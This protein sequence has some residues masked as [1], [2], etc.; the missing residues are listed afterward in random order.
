MKN[1]VGSIFL[2]IGFICMMFACFSVTVLFP[3]LNFLS[4]VSPYIFWGGLGTMLIGYTIIKGRA[5]VFE[6]FATIVLGALVWI[7]ST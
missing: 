1:K 7:I 4:P 5:G 2:T 6:L 3:S